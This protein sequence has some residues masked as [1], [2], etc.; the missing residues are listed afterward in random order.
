MVGGAAVI[1]R[2]LDEVVLQIHAFSYKNM[3][4]QNRQPA[5]QLI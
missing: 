2:P 4:P 5:G 1:P 3:T